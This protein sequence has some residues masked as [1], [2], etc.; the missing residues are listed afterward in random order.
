MVAPEWLEALLPGL[1]KTL[2]T[3]TEGTGEVQVCLGEV[4]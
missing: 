1:D 3:F 2:V 4:I